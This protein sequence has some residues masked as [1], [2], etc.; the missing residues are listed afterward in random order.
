MGYIIKGRQD[1]ALNGISARSVG[2]VVDDLTPPPMAQQRYTVWA[3]GGDTD[4]ISPD[5]EFDSPEYRITARIINQPNFDNSALYAFI[6]D[7]RTLT[8]SILDGYYF[9]VQRVLGISPIST[10]RGREQTYEIGFIL[11]PFKYLIENPEI[12]VT[13]N[14]ISGVGNRYSRPI[15]KLTGCNGAASLTVNGQTLTIAASGT[16]YVDTERMLVYDSSNANVLSKTA[17]ILPFIQ[18]GRNT[19]VFSGATGLTVKRNGRCY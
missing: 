6:S 9:K 3:T 2:L 19:V 15:W 5:G 8:L 18:P 7:A 11:A 4:L 17:G 14:E 12:E 16:I 13:E 10:Y 1:F